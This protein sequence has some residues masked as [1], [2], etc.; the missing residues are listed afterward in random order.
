MTRIDKMKTASLRLA[1][2]SALVLATAAARA[3]EITLSVLN[4][5]PNNIDYGATFMQYVDEVN[6][7]GAGKIKL[8]V[9]PFGSVPTMNIANAVRSGVADM[10]NI[11]P[12]FYQTLLPWG[13]GI[14][15]ATIS[16]AEMHRNGAEAFI[17]AAHNEKVGVEYLTT[18][19]DGDSFVLYL[20]D[21]K[22]SKPEDLKGMKIRVTSIYRAMFGAFG[23]EL[24]NSPFTEL[25]SMLERGVIE[26]F[27]YSSLSIRDNG[28]SKFINYRIEPTF[29]TPNNAIIVNLGK[30]RSLPQE[31]RDLMKR[32][33][34]QFASDYPTR[35]GQGRTELARKQV[36]EDGITIVTF[37]GDDARRWLDTAYKAGWE[38]I[39]RIDPVNGPKLRELITRK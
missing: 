20:R 8:E 22:L 17:N 18:Y 28:W 33:A 27:G 24:I 25:T 10:A 3:Q 12:A 7:E 9:R 6:K 14:K 16:H 35:Y 26:G 39:D 21:K 36:V 29:Y 4:Y 37:Q 13:D 11:P 2:I 30:W 23:A 32:K 15:L 31:T 38:E 34:I 1:I 19:G 5:F